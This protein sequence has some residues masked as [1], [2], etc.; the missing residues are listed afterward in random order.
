MDDNGKSVCSQ[1]FH[2]CRANAATSAGHED[3]RDHL[4]F[5]CRFGSGHQGQQR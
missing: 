1:I 3:G 2:D 5:A 4:F